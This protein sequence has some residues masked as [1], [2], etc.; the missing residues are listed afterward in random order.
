MLKGTSVG[1]WW[2]MPNE[3]QT[4]NGLENKQNIK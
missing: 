3:N 1:A 4:A 2:G